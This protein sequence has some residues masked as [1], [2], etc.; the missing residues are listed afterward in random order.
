MQLRRAL[1]ADDGHEL[2]A[3]TEATIVHIWRDGSRAAA[4]EVEVHVDAPD[5]PVGH[6][7][8]ATAMPDDVEPIAPDADEG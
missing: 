2:P 6:W 5:A 7:H 3:G 4:Y 8:L 1:T